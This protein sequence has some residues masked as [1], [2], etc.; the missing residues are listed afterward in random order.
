M[1]SRDL[2]RYGINLV[3]WYIRIRPGTYIVFTII[4]QTIIS[5]ESLVILS[6]YI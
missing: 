6:D 3:L 2:S 5:L 1:W 4:S